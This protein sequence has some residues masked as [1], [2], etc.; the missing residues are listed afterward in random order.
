[1]RAIALRALL[2]GL[3]AKPQDRPGGVDDLLTPREQ[4]PQFHT[5]RS[6]E[7]CKVWEEPCLELHK[8]QLVG[9]VKLHTV[10]DGIAIHVGG[11]MLSSNKVLKTNSRDNI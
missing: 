11:V 1:M 2:P 8:Q 6:W 3:A 5:V 9:R 10:D 7:V 4:L